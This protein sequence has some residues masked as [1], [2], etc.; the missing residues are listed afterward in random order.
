MRK[1][2]EEV[3]EGEDGELPENSKSN[4]PPKS[5]R[6]NSNLDDFEGEQAPE[7]QSNEPKE[8]KSFLKRKTK[9]P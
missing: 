3:N 9:A 8:K 6:K 5:E 7:D 2:D 4:P 1:R